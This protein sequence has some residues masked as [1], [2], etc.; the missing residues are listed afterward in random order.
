MAGEVHTA[1]FADGFASH[2]EVVHFQAVV[3]EGQ[4]HGK[5]Q[6]AAGVADGSDL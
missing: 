5:G 3:R 2:V 6:D 4:Q 1:A